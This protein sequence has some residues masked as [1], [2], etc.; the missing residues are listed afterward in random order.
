MRKVR[1]YDKI[2]LMPFHYSKEQILGLLN[3]F[4]RVIIMCPEC[5]KLDINPYD[6]FEKCNPIGEQIRRDDED[7][8]WR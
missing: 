7:H 3:D 8:E 5:R 2:I 6:H 4:R 1:V